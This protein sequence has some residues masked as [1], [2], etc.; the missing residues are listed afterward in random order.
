MKRQGP[1]KSAG[2]TRTGH[3]PATSVSLCSGHNTLIGGHV[4]SQPPEQGIQ[5]SVPLTSSLMQLMR[6]SQAST[7]PFATFRELV[8]LQDVLPHSSLAT[9]IAP[10]TGCFLPAPTQNE[11]ASM[12]VLHSA[13][14][15]KQKE[16]SDADCCNTRVHKQTRPL[17]GKVSLSI[18][19][20][21]NPCADVIC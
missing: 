2:S 13:L 18:T 3:H 5:D 10:R 20:E 16:A 1:L 17:T 14:E 6:Q 19:K 7:C 4:K 12:Q 21:T 15:G 8:S 11:K 9:S